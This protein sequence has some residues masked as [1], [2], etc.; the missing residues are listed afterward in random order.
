M[1]DEAVEL[2]S[3]GN[4]GAE[5]HF[6]RRHSSLR[7][8]KDQAT[9]KARQEELKLSFLSAKAETWSEGVEKTR[10]LLGLFVRNSEATTLAADP[11]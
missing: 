11:R 10:Y 2:E 6:L 9:L 5:S 7:S 4:G 8:R 1:V 3:G